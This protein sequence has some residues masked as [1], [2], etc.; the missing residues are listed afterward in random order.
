MEPDSYLEGVKTVLSI[1]ENFDALEFV[2][3]GGGF[4]IPYKKQDGEQR[5]DI[6]E[7]GEKLNSIIVEWTEKYGREIMFKIEPGRYIAGECGVLLGTVHTIKNNYDLTFVGT[8]LGFNVLSRPMMYDSHH[9][10]EVYKNGAVAKSNKE[11][12]TVVGNIC[13]SGDIM[14]KDRELPQ[15]D[16]GD[17]L[18]VMNAGAYGY[19]MASN[20]NNRLRPAEILIKADG[21]AVLIRRRDTLEDIM[22]NFE[23]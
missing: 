16:E 10:I 1:A 8:D 20:Y 6:K 7:L 9:D 18:G 2:D 11:T 5:L 19:S 4:G 13:E 12:V 14:A 21:S 15:V 17:L 23:F 22:R 3:F